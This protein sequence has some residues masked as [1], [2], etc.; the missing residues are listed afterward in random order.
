METWV[1]VPSN[2][3]Q[4]LLRVLLYFR[5]GLNG[6]KCLLKAICETAE[7]PYTEH[8]GVVGDIIH[9]IFTWVFH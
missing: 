7:E 3:K 8:N 9:I 5:A 4:V 2:F 1:N 6:E